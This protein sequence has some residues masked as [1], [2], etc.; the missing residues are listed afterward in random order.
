GSVNNPNI[1]RSVEEY[2]EIMLSGDTLDS[3]TG[4]VRFI[5]DIDFAS[6]ETAIKTR[7]NFTL[8]DENNNSITSIEGNGMTISGIYLDVGN[9]EEKSI[10]LFAQVVNSYVKNLNLEFATTAETDGQF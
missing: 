5:N 8:G 10:G 4:Y 6:D 2:N 1:I 7:V 9:A 3:M